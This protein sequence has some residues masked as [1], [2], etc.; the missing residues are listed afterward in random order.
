MF[1]RHFA[2]WPPNVS[3][4]LSIPETSLY[5]N[6]EVSATRYP[7]KP[8]IIYYGRV[9]TFSELRKHVDALAG[10]LAQR[11]GVADGDRV[12]L[13]VQNSPQYLIGYY[14]ILRANAVVLPAN[15]ML[16]SDE[17]R[18]LSQD[19]GARVALFG[20]ELLEEWLP[21]L[22][23]GSISHGVAAAYAD[24]LP[25]PAQLLGGA[26]PDVVLA[27]ARPLPAVEAPATL[28]GWQAALA[29]DCPPPAHTRGSDD[30]AVLPYTSG[31][32]GAPKGCMHT[33]GTVMSTAAAQ[34]AWAGKTGNNVGLATLPMFHVTGMQANVN[35]PI[36]A[37]TTVVIMTRWDREVA[38][39]LIEACKVTAF[40]GITTMMVDFLANPALDTYD[41]SSLNY[42]SGGGAA[43]PDAVARQLLDR[44]G[45][46][47]IE[48]YGLTE[49][50][51]PTHVN[52]SHRPKRQCAG[53]PIFQTDA[54]VIDVDT[55][56]EKGPGE[57]G[58]II[59]HGPQVFKGYWNRPDAT[60]EAFIELDGKRFFRTGDLGY[61]DDEGYFFI[62]DRLKRMI[63]ASGFKVWPAEVEAMLYDHPAVAEACI[64]ARRDAH[65]GETVKAVVV[66]KPGAAPI[67]EQDLI[68]WA[69]G[70]MAAYKVPR[71]VEFI[72]AL[73]K[74]G[75]GK[76]FWRGLQEVENAQQGNR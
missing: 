34:F 3:K 58:E 53:I 43:M 57:T 32:T 72:D 2:H 27:P 55:L 46:P 37:G 5:Y 21:L 66:L 54:R 33:H 68:D 7:E 19:S 61:Y 45:L 29:A 16:K 23:D 52:P 47:F 69:R 18:Y 4:D 56:A 73:P 6:L 1:S 9:I 48:G 42:I 64:I 51:A 8:A 28:L 12:I 35:L 30:L 76:V 31:T 24:Y 15:P 41:L 11:C 65:R 36:L 71:H 17:L 74:T 26:L 39:R 13:D 25:P 38:A 70:K 75:T 22:A 49:T 40:T 10:Y 20:Q 44:L 62:T 14:A 60:E 50:I 67:S 63:N 59:V